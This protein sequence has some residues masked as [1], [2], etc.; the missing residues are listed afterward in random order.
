MLAKRD[1]MA[2]NS[3]ANSSVCS[4]QAWASHLPG[5]R[6]RKRLTGA[7]AQC[8]ALFLEVGTHFFF[9]PALSSYA[10]SGL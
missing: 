3:Y 7:V 10:L 8:R 9:V 2:S 5:R 4:R 6:R 1:F